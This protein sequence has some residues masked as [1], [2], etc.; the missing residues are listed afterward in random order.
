MNFNLRSRVRAVVEQPKPG[1]E[2]TPAPADTTQAG[3]ED[4]TEEDTDATAELDENGVPIVKPTP[5]ED[6]A[7]AASAAALTG[8]ARVKAILQASGAEA[9]RPLAEF[10]AL[11]T[12]IDASTAS[13]IIGKVS[14]PAAG[15]A[16]A[17]K[18][19]AFLDAMGKVANPKTKAASAAAPEAGTPAAAVTEMGS[20]LRKFGLAK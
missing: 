2:A 6:A 7:A 9:Q 1:A 3:A 19:N 20:A 12:E 14:I 4:T 13:K 11:D 18:P 5:E 10:L 15:A 8:T 16:A 17:G